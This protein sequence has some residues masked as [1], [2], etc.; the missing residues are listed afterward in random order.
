MVRRKLPPVLR[1]TRPGCFTAEGIRLV[2]EI[3]ASGWTIEYLAYTARAA[4]TPRAAALLERARA[5]GL[6]PVLVGE[7]RM[8]SLAGTVTPQGVLAVVRRPAGNW[9]GLVA[10]RPS[11]L[12][13]LDGLQDPGNVGTVIRAADAAACD[14]VLCLAGT[15]DPFGP[16]AVRASMGSVLHLPVYTGVPAGV[17]AAALVRA[18]L[19]L[20]SADPGGEAVLAEQ[21]LRQAVALIL[22]SEARGPGPAWEEAVRVRI[23]MPGRAES[24]NVALAAGIFLYETIRQR[25]GRGAG[26]ETFLVT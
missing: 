14:G 24:L 22:G 11:L 25:S 23:P 9:A 8:N 19:S 26:T 13:I 7:R 4:A 16:K 2:E 12:V 3:L 17:C 21:N 10:G 6:A 1:R 20:I 18:G 15:C 5:K